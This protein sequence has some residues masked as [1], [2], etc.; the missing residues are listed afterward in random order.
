MIGRRKKQPPVQRS[1]HLGQQKQTTF[2]YSSNRS[3][4][5]RVLSRQDTQDAEQATQ[6]R[7]RFARRLKRTPYL[8]GGLAAFA[9]AI[10]L[11]LLL[12]P[13]KIVF[14]GE[15]GPLRSD[16]PYAALVSGKTS[17]LQSSS[18]FTI[19]RQQLTK[20]MQAQFPELVQVAVTTPLLAN[21]AVV[22]LEVSKPA[23]ILTSG[24]DTY[25]LDTRGVALLDTARER[26]LAKTDA[27]PVVTDQSNLPVELGKQALT[28]SQ[29]GFI[30]ELNH[31]AQAKNLSLV[32]INLSAGAGEL[33]VRYNDLPYFVKYNVNE[34]ARKS[35][36]TFYAT[37]EYIE[38][39]K[40]KPAEYI[41][42]RI[43]ERAYVK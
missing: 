38:R 19:N 25:L 18:K 32:S 12:T 31:Q 34:D 7:L 21:H 13:P 5:E 39:T 6:A 10:Y 1:P 40:V 36:G 14:Y 15:Q 8:V 20:D 33:T 42:V 26:P 28:S 35:F 16:S 41:D 4:T 11:S 29:T 30:L 2:R 37:K 3:Q 27:L 17:N 43:P 9:G 22:E 23:L 24:N